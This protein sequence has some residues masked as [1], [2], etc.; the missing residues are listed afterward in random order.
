MMPNLIGKGTDVHV[1]PA[2][3]VAQ[4]AAC[5]LP[6]RPVGITSPAIQHVD[7]LVQLTELNSSEDGALPVRAGD[8]KVQVTPPSLVI[9]T[10]GLL[11]ILF[12]VPT[13]TGA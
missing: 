10:A 9:M 7:A 4:I 1:C 12:P 6:R 5:E 2:S 13:C 8:T 3:L 11:R